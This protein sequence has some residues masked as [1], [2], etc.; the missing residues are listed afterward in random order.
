MLVAALPGV[1]VKADGNDTVVVC[2]LGAWG[3]GDL[4]YVPQLGASVGAYGD[5]ATV[6]GKPL[7]LED[8]VGYVCCI[9]HLGL[10]DSTCSTRVGLPVPLNPWILQLQRLSAFYR[11]GHRCAS[12]PVPSRTTAD[13]RPNASSGATKCHLQVNTS[14]TFDGA[15]IFD[16]EL[17]DVTSQEV[18]GFSNGTTYYWRVKAG[19]DG[20]WSDR[21]SVRS[22]LVNQVP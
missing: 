17:G 22:I 13:F 11:L 3:I 21:S 8:G 7:F 10:R 4:D 20:G 2:A 9:D 15:S 1:V 12:T 5:T 6:L 16:S 14:S 18:T 19:N